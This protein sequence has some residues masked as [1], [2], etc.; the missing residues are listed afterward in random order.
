[1][2]L[3]VAL[4]GFDPALD[5]VAEAILAADPTGRRT[6]NVM[7][8]SFDQ[9]YDGGRT[10]VYHVDQLSPTQKTH[11]GTFVEVNM[12]KEFNFETVGVKFDYRIAGHD[13]DAKFSLS[14]G[15]MLPPEVIGHL[16]LVMQASDDEARFDIGVVRASAEWLTA[17]G[18]RDKK[19]ALRAGHRDKITWIHRGATMPPNVLATLA[20]PDLDVILSK[21]SGQQK[22]NEVFRRAPGRRISRAAIETLA[23]QRD[24]LKR[25]RRNGGARTPLAKEGIIIMN[26]DYTWQRDI[27]KALGAEPPQE[28]EFVSLHITP[29]EPGWTGPQ[30]TIEGRAWRCGTP[31]EALASASELPEILQEAGKTDAGT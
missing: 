8:Q 18:N 6:G 26:G 23:M 3:P 13:V 11:L 20:R 9:L 14:G 25:V 15:W 12:A 31:A 17:G 28:G 16:C 1:M 2:T 30:T 29:A 5:E 19:V 4:P 27:V 24:P 21:K 22:V 7:R 10:G